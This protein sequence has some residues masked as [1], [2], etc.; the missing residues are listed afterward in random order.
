M[1]PLDPSLIRRVTSYHDPA[2]GRRI[3]GLWRDDA[4][5]AGLRLNGPAND[6]ADMPGQIVEAVL[7]GDDEPDETRPG[8]IDAS[9]VLRNVPAG[10]AR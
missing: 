5:H 8:W 10:T 9:V 6:L 7:L 1:T 3:V 4:Q 2:T